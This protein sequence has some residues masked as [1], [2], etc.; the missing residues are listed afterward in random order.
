MLESIEKLR[1]YSWI[2]GG[3][4][5]EYLDAIE[6]EIAERFMELPVDADG[7]PIR[8]GDMMES[9]HFVNGCGKPRGFVVGLVIGDVENIVSLDTE[10]GQKD[11]AFAVVRHYKPRT[12]EDV[13]M[14]AG[15]SVAAI[16]DVAAEIREVLWSDA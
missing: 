10:H 4:V 9:I 14:N 13:L 2:G 3:K 11:F 1:G 15:V 5:N 7:V 12:V 8:M 16:S 6:A